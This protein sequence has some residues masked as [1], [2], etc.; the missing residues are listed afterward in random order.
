MQFWTNI[1]E[2]LNR[3]LFHHFLTNFFTM[4]MQLLANSFSMSLKQF[5]LKLRTKLIQNVPK[6][7]KSFFFR[8]NFLV[9]FDLFSF[10]YLFSAFN[11][12]CVY[13]ARWMTLMHFIVGH[14]LMLMTDGLE[15][16]L[17]R[18][19]KIML[20]TSNFFINIK[21]KQINLARYLFVQGFQKCICFFY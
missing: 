17:Q 6:L 3:I 14:N 12:D 2:I 8:V 9:K 13:R 18:A 4:S 10:A 16:F 11:I 15:I 1:R 5:Y 19:K 21:T 20:E 7:Q